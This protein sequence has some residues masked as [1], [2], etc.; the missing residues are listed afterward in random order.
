MKNKKN[1]FVKMRYTISLYQFGYIFNV[2]CINGVSIM[3]SKLYKNKT[4]CRNTA[5]R[6]AENCGLK[7]RE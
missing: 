5:K 1:Y 4:Q 7:F 2:V 6:F 3:E